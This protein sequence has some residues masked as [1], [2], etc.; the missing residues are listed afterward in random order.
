MD[1]KVRMWSLIIIEA[2]VEMSLC[3]MDFKGEE[4]GITNR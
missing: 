1:L 2:G 4:R 3:T